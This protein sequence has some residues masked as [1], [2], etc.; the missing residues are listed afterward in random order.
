MPQ[1]AVSERRLDSRSRI[2]DAALDVF[3]ER[4]FE[5]AS[6]RQIA[7]RAGTNHGLIA[8]YFGGKK[9]LWQA[10]VDH[11]F[12]DM[13]AQLEAALEKNAEA[14]ARTRVASVIREHVQYVAQHPAFVRLMYEEGKRR[15]ERMRWIVDRHVQPLYD[16]LA[17]LMRDVGRPIGLPSEVSPAHVFYALA[18]A[19][20]LIFHQAEECRR[21]SGVD[22][23]DPIEVERHVQVIEWLLLGPAEAAVRG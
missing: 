8:Y 5:G 4:G 1:A 7:A 16:V 13:Q 3:T 18:G 20:G 19:S 23:F 12:G 22:A 21:L 14:D 10:T 11:A 9:K 2:L 6:A 17:K 15:G